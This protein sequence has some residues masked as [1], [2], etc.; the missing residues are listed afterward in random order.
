MVSP[1][2]P[3]RDISPP[4]HS[5]RDNHDDIQDMD[6]IQATI[7]PT[8][9]D[10]FK[11]L[12]SHNSMVSARNPS[13]YVLG[14]LIPLLMIGIA[15]QISAGIQSN[16]PEVVAGEIENRTFSLEETGISGSYVSTPVVY[17]PV[18][19]SVPA[20]D[21]L[22]D[23]VVQNLKQVYSVFNPDFVDY[24][25]MDAVAAY[26]HQNAKNMLK[27]RTLMDYDP[28][29]GFEM[30]ALGPSTSTSGAVD[31]GFTISQSV[32]DSIPFMLS[33]MNQFTQNVDATSGSNGSEAALGLRFLLT[34]QTFPAQ[35]SENTDIASYVVPAFLTLAFSFYTTFVAS[36]LVQEK[37]QGQKAHLQN[38]GVKPSTYYLA[39]FVIDWI[40]YLFPV[41]MS[42]VL[43][44]EHRLQM[45]TA[46]SWVP[47]FLVLLIAG[48]PF[49]TFGYLLSLFFNNQQSVSQVL[50]IGMS[51]I[52]F[53][54]FFFVQFVFGGASLLAIL[55]V[56]LIA[57]SFALERSISAI[58]VAQT[59]GSPYTMKDT[60]DITKPPFCVMI[61]FVVQTF[62]YLG[63]IFWIEN[64]IQTRRS[65]I[66]FFFR[67]SA[68]ND[69]T[70][71]ESH[72]DKKAET[73][74]I[75]RQETSVTFDGKFRERD[76]EVVE[77]TLRLKGSAAAGD[78]DLDAVRL[79][80]LSKVFH[81]QSKKRDLVILDD[82]YLS[83]KKNECFGYLGPNG[84]GKTT[85][86]KILTGAEGPTS[87][88]GTIMG[89]P[90]APFHE[91]LR[92]MIGICPQFDVLWP[93]LK[94]RDHL[95]LFARIKGVA[96]QDV[97]PA[98]QQM[99]DEMGLAPLGEKLAKTFS[100]GNKRRLSLAM[101]VIGCPK[102]VFLDEPT[103][104]V[105]VSIRQAIWNSIRK[106]KRTSCVILTT[107]SM[108]E[109]DALCDRIG[110]ITNGHI[111][112]LGTSQRLKNT[113]GAGYKVVVKTRYNAATSASSN[114][115][116]TLA[117]EQAV[118]TGRVTLV[119]A[120]GASLEYELTRVEGERTTDMLT[121]LFRLFEQSRDELGIEDYSVSQTTLAQVFIEFAKEQAA[122]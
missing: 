21:N 121:K 85:T 104:G 31:L 111:Q 10:H 63:L 25:S 96:P 23:S 3:P 102:V 14:A 20:L 110:I 48:F 34:L 113:Y 38:M 33:Q 95:R 60:F 37:E 42:F 64:L 29:L 12:V 46:G 87:G 53:I 106:L 9:W 119:Q 15:I 72:E 86:I 16:I 32:N 116:V 5:H 54:P 84:A 97:E 62:I 117:L 99:I 61:L 47:Y 88:K 82:V 8:K 7:T 45:I 74:G 36:N 109:A 78:Q 13:V 58:A 44:G 89:L 19:K 24:P 83:F 52:V 43:M 55:L 4:P 66:D 112:A 27:N 35:G 51:L 30:D 81:L 92:T 122:L 70:K 41:V 69:P 91:D 59:T 2:L 101:A 1:T 100:G 80:G 28:Q 93:N 98:V 75:R 11:A 105:D 57:P 76:V 115:H 118:G 67:R 68:Y 73:A 56:G 49:I 22:T 114:S 18:V 65:P 120:L 103:T 39:R 108:E 94:V 77:E 26:E 50:G 6:I 79:F 107:H 17:F 71:Y 90:I 40:C